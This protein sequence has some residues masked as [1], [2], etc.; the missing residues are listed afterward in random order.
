MRTSATCRCSSCLARCSS[1]SK[2]TLPLQ[3]TTRCTCAAGTFVDSSMTV[4]K[5]AVGQF[6]ELR[7]RQLVTQQALRRHDDQRL[8]ERPHHLPPQHVKHLRGR[9]RHAHLH[10]VLGAQLQETLEARRG[11]LRPLPFVAVRQKQ[12]ESAEPAPLRFARTDELV[13]DDLR[14]VGE[15]AELAFPDRRASRDRW[16]SSRIRSPAP[17]LRRA[18]S[19]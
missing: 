4:L 7:H 19:R 13:D 16:S 2:Y 10:V 11:M 6:L 5:P 14:A 18:P 3:N 9:R 15:I 12:R 8:A 1:R 17:P